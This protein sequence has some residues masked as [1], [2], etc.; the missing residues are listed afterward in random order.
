MIGKGFYITVPL[1]SANS[2]RFEHEK[3][4]MIS[5]VCRKDEMKDKNPLTDYECT[6]PMTTD[7]VHWF[8][9]LFDELGI[10]VWIDGDT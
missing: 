4:S 1:H 9:D 6:S 3:F 10:K 2:D 5:C 7:M 8:L